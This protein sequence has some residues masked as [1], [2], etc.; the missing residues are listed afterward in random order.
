M[1]Y[2][3]VVAELYS[4]G[5]ALRPDVAL[6]MKHL[7]EVQASGIKF[8]NDEIDLRIREANAENGYSAARGRSAAGP[9]GVAVI[10]IMGI[11]SHRMNMVSNISGAG[12]TSIERLTAQFRAAMN[13]ERV[14]AIIFDVDSPGGSVE[15]VMELAS[16]IFNARKQKPSI[17]VANAQAA[18][19]AY[20][21]ASSAGELVVTPSGQVGSIGVYVA[22]QDESKALENDGIRITLISAGKYKTEGNPSEPLGDEARASLQGKVDA[23]YGMFVKGVSQNRGA[24]QAAVREGFGQGRMVLAADAVKQNMADRVA[25]LDDVL[26]RYGTSTTAVSESASLHSLPARADRPPDSPNDNDEDDLTGQCTCSCDACKEC[27]QK[28][29]NSKVKSELPAISRRRRELQ[30]HQ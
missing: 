1:K 20:W 8:S 30:L 17:A 2:P 14:K 23:Y 7:I 11:I 28:E 24:S 3:H 13:D 22:H 27:E 15:G 10:P 26:A 19:A 16:E 21:L 4:R 25:T 6:A 29:T 5:W 12:G 9:G 18:S